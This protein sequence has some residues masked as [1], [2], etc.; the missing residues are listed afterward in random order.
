[1]FH[2]G[3]ITISI[4]ACV[5]ATYPGNGQGWNY[6]TTAYS[7]TAQQLHLDAVG[8]YSH[9]QWDESI[10]A[11]K[12][13]IEKFPHYPEIPQAHFFLAEA[14]MQ[15]E[16]YQEAY[17]TYQKFLLTKPIGE[18]ESRSLFRMG[19]AAF[20]EGND[21]NGVSLLELFVKENPGHAL[22]EYALPYLGD[23][24]LRRMEPQLAQKVF[25]R[26]LE[27]HP[28]GELAN[29][30]RYGLA[31][32]WH[33]QGFL[34][35]AKRLY[36][37][38]SESD[39]V[40][41]ASRA[42]LQLAQI[43][44]L[45]NE[46]KLAKDHLSNAL[47]SLDDVQLQAEA[48]YWL[49]RVYVEEKDL[50]T[51][52][53][54]LSEIKGQT[55]RESLT[56]AVLL[57][58][59]QIAAKL[60]E[61]D[62]ALIALNE[63]I[64]RFPQARQTESAVVL[65]IDLG[66]KVGAEETDFYETLQLFSDSYPE[67]ANRIAVYEK[68]GR[69][70]FDRQRY[71]QAAPWFEKLVELGQQGLAEDHPEV[72]RWNYLY[73]LNLIGLGDFKAAESILVQID[74][75]EQTADTQPLIHIAL[76]TTR[77]GL[78]KYNSAIPSYQNYLKLVE[79]HP[80][81]GDQQT[82][83]RARRELTLSLAEAGLWSDAR[84]AFNDF[85][86]KYGDSEEVLE[87]AE[88]LA[89]RAYRSEV[90]TK[91][92]DFLEFLLARSPRPEKE[93]NYLSA[94]GWIRQEMGETESAN[95]HFRKLMEKYPQHELTL[96]AAMA[97]GKHYEESD[98]RSRAIETYSFL[99]NDHDHPDSD[100]RR[101]ASL[102][103][104]YL[105]QKP[106][107]HQNLQQARSLL[108]NYLDATSQPLAADEAYY[109][110]GWVLLDL[111]EPEQAV[112]N[113]RRLLQ[114][115]PE[116]KF[117]N[118]VSLRLAQLELKLGRLQESREL[119][120]ALIKQ[121][122][123]PFNLRIQVVYLA[124]EV[125]VKQNRWSDVGLLTEELIRQSDRPDIAERAYYWR[126]ESHYRQNRFDQ[127]LDSFEHLIQ[128]SEG[129]PMVGIDPAILP[130][131]WLRAAQS[132]GKISQWKRASRWAS[133]GLEKY[134]LFA[135]KHEF[136][137]IRARALEDS[138]LLSDA[139]EL[140]QAIVDSTEAGHTETAAMAQWRIGETYFHQEDYSQ[141]IR[142]YYRVDTAYDYEKWRSAALLQAGKCQEH[143]DN[144]QQAERLYKRLIEQFPNSPFTSEAKERLSKLS[145][146]RV[147]GN[148][149]QAILK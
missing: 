135:N 66:L 19:E 70:Y 116:S 108:E 104:A 36:R 141:A 24:R 100:L 121:Q 54:L 80:L 40:Y 8:Y 57:D 51:A 94:L 68:A 98:Q 115:F 117:R 127:A 87:I 118:D 21:Q 7:Q 33:Q 102:R 85:S 144:V 119:V 107:D 89:D 42:E 3:K 78:K 128:Q 34:D 145:G 16:R 126:A 88:F 148:Q 6:G 86:T 83:K 146:M 30:C 97:L 132:A 109:Q 75:S 101:L 105:L 63:L 47:S 138:G 106:G 48:T 55:L 130:W 2:F 12:E 71:E 143:L 74:I 77:F 147:T 37:F 44:L 72:Q 60:G 96:A 14:L 62:E 53:D 38:V 112:E 32:C 1:M 46:F 50:K 15:V 29:R 111:D 123:L 82:I 90:T 69:F 35:D 28:H 91:A 10:I 65:K 114:S 92:L 120:E 45:Q 41:F 79:V 4:L 113:F 43:Y 49:A 25:E 31:R 20:R 133:E 124:G 56:T 76:A 61:T 95:T 103:L 64:E 58:W 131:I 23:I 13:L 5:L 26:S 59:A 18:L 22:L 27:L 110:L 125:A 11:F 134:P 73:S 81:E 84:Q 139:R 140:Y 39:S 129:Q 52:L 99:V 67:S 142:S 9:Q 17:F 93:P 122:N 137:F 136:D 149:D